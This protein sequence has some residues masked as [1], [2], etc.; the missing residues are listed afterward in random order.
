[1]I[2][3]PAEYFD[4]KSSR[5]YPVTL[6][7]GDGGWVH[8][9]GLARD[10]PYPLTELRVSDRIGNT[11]RNIYLPD[12]ATLTTTDND[13]VDRYLARRG[14]SGVA[15][16]IH[17]LESRLAYALLLL[18]LAVGVSWLTVTQG[19]PALAK[20]VA[21]ALPAETNT[22]LGRGVLETM[23]G[24]VFQPSTLDAATQAR[25]CPRASSS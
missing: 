1:M 17:R 7:F 11:P 10:L 12:G 8:V 4:G 3:I 19:I 25:L 22:M 13:T 23:D 9:I 20:H 6:R 21:Y 2:E 24:F 16:L 18:V 15:R 5:G 14:H